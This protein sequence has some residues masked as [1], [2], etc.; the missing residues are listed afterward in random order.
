MAHAIYQ[1]RLDAGAAIDPSRA[2]SPAGGQTL[3]SAYRTMA[4]AMRE[5]SIPP[6]DPDDPD[7]PI[8][9]QLVNG[10]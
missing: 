5:K 8:P 2:L 3:R 4:T 9:F 1:S 7:D 10:K 6:Y